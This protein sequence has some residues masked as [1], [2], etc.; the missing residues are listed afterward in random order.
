M[1]SP[2]RIQ[3]AAWNR[4]SPSS[5]AKPATWPSSL[6][7]S[8]GCRPSDG[9]PQILNDAIFPNESALKRL[10][11]HI[12]ANHDAIVVDSGSNNTGPP[13]LPKSVIPFFS[14]QMKEFVA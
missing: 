10:I 11:I 2:R 6:I 5:V 1:I 12:V 4:T 14:S 7:P 8:A 9:A 3:R 13:K